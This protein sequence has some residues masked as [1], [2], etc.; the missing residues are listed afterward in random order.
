[1]TRLC[2][3]HKLLGSSTHDS[4]LNSSMSCFSTARFSLDGAEMDARV[5]C[6]RTLD[7][8]ESGESSKEKVLVTSPLSEQNDELRSV[9]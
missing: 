3:Y 6:S 2:C 1:M 4:T 5:A 9:V 7:G 8:K